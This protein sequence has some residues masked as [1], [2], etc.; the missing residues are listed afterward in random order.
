[1][2]N[3]AFVLDSALRQILIQMAAIIIGGLVL[4]Y[5][6]HAAYRLGP[7]ARHMKRRAGPSLGN[8]MRVCRKH[9]AATLHELADRLEP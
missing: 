7:W 8:K 3:T 2:D 5:L 4:A 9:A 1:M 6:L